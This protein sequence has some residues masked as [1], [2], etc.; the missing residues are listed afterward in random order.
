MRVTVSRDEPRAAV[1]SCSAN[2]SSAQPCRVVWTFASRID[3]P[4]RPK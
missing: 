4:A 1:V 3:S 2:V